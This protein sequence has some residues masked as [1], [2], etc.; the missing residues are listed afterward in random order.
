MLAYV[1]MVDVQLVADFANGSEDGPVEAAAWQPGVAEPLLHE[2]ASGASGRTG[3][4]N[5]AAVADKIAA[6]RVHLSFSTGLAV[7]EA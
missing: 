2:P 4:G 3:A 1:K 7:A 5:A 6:T